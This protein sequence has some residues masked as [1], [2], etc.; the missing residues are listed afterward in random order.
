MGGTNPAVGATG[1]VRR[2]GVGSWLSELDFF[3]GV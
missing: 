1:S 3:V 2:I